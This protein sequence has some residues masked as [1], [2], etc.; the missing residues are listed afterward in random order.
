MQKEQ[1]TTETFADLMTCPR[2]YGEWVLT[3]RDP[4]AWTWLLLWARGVELKGRQILRVQTALSGLFALAASCGV[5]PSHQDS[6]ADSYD[7]EAAG[8]GVRHGTSQTLQLLTQARAFIGSQENG[9]RD[10]KVQ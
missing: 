10:V 2:V 4:Q 5:R 1:I 6:A 3:T 8:R 9:H 7:D